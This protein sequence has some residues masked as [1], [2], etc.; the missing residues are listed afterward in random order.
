MLRGEHARS[1]PEASCLEVLKG[2]ADFSL[3]FRIFKVAGKV[4]L[5]YL[6]LLKHQERHGWCFWK[7]TD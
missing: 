2:L 4:R 3:R 6:D 5:S 1:K 7:L